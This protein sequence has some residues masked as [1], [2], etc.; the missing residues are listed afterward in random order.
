MKTGATTVSSQAQEIYFYAH[1]QAIV[2]GSEDEEDEQIAG[3]IV[4]F[5]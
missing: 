4:S 5:A 2:D 1:E 3:F